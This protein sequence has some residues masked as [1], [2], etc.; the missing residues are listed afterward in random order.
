[1]NPP[2]PVCGVCLAPVEAVELDHDP[3]RSC[4]LVTARCHGETEVAEVP[5]LREF[6][7]E[8]DWMLARAEGREVA[9][10]PRA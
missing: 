9:E 3:R 6:E 7:A 2:W 10:V 1:M 5:E 8:L 4:V